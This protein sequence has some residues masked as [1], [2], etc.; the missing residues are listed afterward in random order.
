MKFTAGFIKVA[1]DP[2]KWGAMVKS[3]GTGLRESGG[4]TIK[5]TLK[6]KGLKHIKDSVDAAG[7]IGN[8]LKTQKGREGLMRGLGKAAPSLGVTG[9]YAAG[10]KKV[11]DKVSNNPQQGYY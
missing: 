8:A 1:G 9:L 5:D 7:G 6:L 10:A 2:I 3:L 11:Y 4:A